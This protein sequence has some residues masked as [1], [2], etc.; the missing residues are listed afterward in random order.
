MTNSAVPTLLKLNIYL[1]ASTYIWGAPFQEEGYA[2]L[3]CNIQLNTSLPLWIVFNV[4]SNNPYHT[5][6]ALQENKKKNVVS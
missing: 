2:S 1:P 5:I 4:M 6:H 3:D